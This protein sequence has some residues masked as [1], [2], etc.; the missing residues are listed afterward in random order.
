[1]K[2]FRLIVPSDGIPR[3]WWALEA[4][5][6]REFGGFTR[7][8]GDGAWRDPKTRRTLTEPVVIYDIAALDEGP[9]FKALREIA[10]YVCD[11]FEQQSVYIRDAHNEV[12]LVIEA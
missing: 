7:Y 5:I 9:G 2:E 1:M 11:K 3:T 6:V 12:F 4:R 10:V 8:K